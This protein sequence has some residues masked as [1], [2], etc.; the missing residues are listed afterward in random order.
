VWI[1]MNP[2]TLYL[3]SSVVNFREI[4][5]RLVG[6]SVRAWLD[7]HLAAGAGEIVVTLTGLALVFALAGFLHRQKIFLR[8]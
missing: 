7:A 8:V 3:L 4:A 1:G 5:S 6:G 2:I